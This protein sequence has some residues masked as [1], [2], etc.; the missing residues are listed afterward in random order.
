MSNND[1]VNLNKEDM[2][3]ACALLFYKELGILY[4]YINHFNITNDYTVNIDWKQME[5]LSSIC[6]KNNISMCSIINKDETNYLLKLMNQ[7][8]YIMKKTKPDI[9]KEYINL[10]KI[11]KINYKANSDNYIM[12]LYASNYFQSLGNSWAAKVL[13]IELVAFMQDYTPEEEFTFTRKNAMTELSDTWFRT[14]M[15]DFIEHG[16]IKI[17]SQKKGCKTRY[18]RGKY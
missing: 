8:K 7:I 13:L 14:L 1:A 11:R 9:Y 18:I 4:T 3:K 10:C 5:L 15:T 12:K 16:I 6:N 17:A 2:T